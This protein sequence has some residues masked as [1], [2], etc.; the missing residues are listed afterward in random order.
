M[1][2]PEPPDAA[3]AAVLTVCGTP[4]RAA[5]VCALWQVHTQAPM[6]TVASIH[7]S[8]DGH[9]VCV[10]QWAAVAA[11]TVAAVRAVRTGDS[12]LTLVGTG[13]SM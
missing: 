6:G 4:P 7:T 11:V 8:T 1:S 2:L 9:C 10:W 5:T 13:D 3:T 12:R